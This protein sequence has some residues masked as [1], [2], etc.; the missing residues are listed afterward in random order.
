MGR[1]KDPRNLSKTG[2]SATNK[3]HHQICRCFTMLLNQKRA[4]NLPELTNNTG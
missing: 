2:Y 1:N 3:N 4:Q